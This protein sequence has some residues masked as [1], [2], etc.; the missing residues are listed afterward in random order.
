MKSSVVHARFGTEDE[1][2][3]PNVVVPRG[4]IA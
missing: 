1:F 3:D 2:S 4:I